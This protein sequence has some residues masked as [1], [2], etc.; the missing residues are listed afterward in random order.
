MNSTKSISSNSH[1][2]WIKNLSNFTSIYLTSGI[3]IIGFLLNICM[4]ILLGNKKLKH[5]FYGY[6]R[7]QAL[8]ATLISFVGLLNFI[9]VKFLK[10]IIN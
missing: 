9:E 7:I 6:L 3:S 1:L 8:I 2:K 4:T 10:I 5:R